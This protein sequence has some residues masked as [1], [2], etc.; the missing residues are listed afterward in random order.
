MTNRLR[1]KFNIAAIAIFTVA[2]VLAACTTTA[3]VEGQA[4][5]SGPGDTAQQFTETR[6]APGADPARAVSPSA[7]VPPGMEP[8]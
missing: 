7:K 2:L 3:Q 8:L 5:P 4:A 1:L 6:Q